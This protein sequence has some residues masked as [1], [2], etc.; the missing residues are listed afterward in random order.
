M[1]EGETL[2][3]ML[4]R[5]ETA[6][7]AGHGLCLDYFGA[8]SAAEAERGLGIH[9][10]AAA[11]EWRGTVEERDDAVSATWQVRLGD[12]LLDFR[13]RITLCMGESVFLVEETVTNRA[14]HAHAFQWVQ[15]VTFGP[16]FL[17]HGEGRLSVSAVR[18]FTDDSAYG[19]RSLV[20]H[21]QPFQWPMALVAGGRKEV[22][23]SKPFS[24]PGYGVLAGMELDPRREMQCLLAVNHRLG[25]GVAYCF[26][27]R[28]FPWMAVWEENESRRE[29]PWSSRT[30]ARGME[31]GT[32]P[33]P[34]GRE[35]TLRRGVRYGVPCWRTLEA[36]SAYTA[37]YVCFL[38][39]VPEGSDGVVDAVVEE[40]GLSLRNAAGDSVQAIAARGVSAF[41]EG[42]S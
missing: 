36:E 7:M 4:E 35:E 3:P 5:T 27:R 23:L 38:F 10:E 26:R 25:L 37:R 34:L 8:P 21:G 19:E 33:L 17:R 41:L 1:A 14:A 30:R 11:L 22:D 31:F 16:P 28:D 18:G 20:A 39:A 9:G 2:D 13:R 40:H 32:T 29:A 15:H 24:S 42:A 12:A 6:G